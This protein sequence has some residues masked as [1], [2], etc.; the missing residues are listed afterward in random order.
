MVLSL[1]T[2]RVVLNGLGA[3]DF[4]LYNVVG[5]AIAMLGFLNAA[6][7]KATQRFISY[8]EGAGNEES[9]IV[10]FNISLILHAIVS[11]AALVLFVGAGFFFFNDIL[12]IPEGRD[13][14]AIVVYASLILSTIFTIFTVPYEAVMNAHE[15]MRIYAFI[16][17]LDAILR[18]LVAYACLFASSD[19]LIVYGILMSIIPAVNFL[20]MAIY[21]HRR[22]AECV[23][24]PF[25]YYN[26]QDMKTMMSFAGWNLFG[27]S[28]T[29][30]GN[31]GQSII[32]NMFFG[33]IVNASLGI[34]Q[35]LQGMMA[36]VAQ[37]MQKALNPVIVKNEGAGNRANMLQWSLRGCKF[38]CYLMLWLVV[39]MV[40]EAPFVL[41]LWLKNVPENAVL[42]FRLQMIRYI[43]EVLVV[44][45]STS[46]MAVGQIKKFNI[47]QMVFILVPLPVMYLLYQIGFEVYWMF[48][49]YI[50]STLMLDI[51]TLALCKKY[52]N[53]SFS[54]YM[55]EVLLPVL[56]TI[57]IMGILGYVAHAFISG[58]YLR[59]ISC[60]IGTWIGMCGSL[61]VFGLNK[62]EKTYI[63]ECINKILK[64]KNKYKH[65]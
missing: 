63:T 16:G 1:V 47:Y 64:K 65:Y 31:Y 56:L 32:V 11:L 57:F 48:I 33:V 38:S 60:F 22:Y 50:I 52:C 55:G 35:Q 49:V 6:M 29:F 61:F 14:A 59:T 62:Q 15:N 21:C 5:G 19:K 25:R 58:N 46:L 9:K 17:I 43:L 20:I 7:A 24:A 37:N 2:T 26:K 28:G 44:S 41:V 53:L 42:F 10:I 13:V 51:A 27:S 45:F 4:G 8:E 39:P 40:I 30:V 18:L 12:N 34:I 54:S 23:L 36:V 3:S